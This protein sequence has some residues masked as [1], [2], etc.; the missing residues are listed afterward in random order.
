MLGLEDTLG[1]G[2]RGDRYALVVQTNAHH[3]HEGE[4][5]IP[6]GDGIIFGRGCAG[7]QVVFCL[8]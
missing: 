3:V 6:T 1:R 7:G 5:D 2:V 4:T 8:S